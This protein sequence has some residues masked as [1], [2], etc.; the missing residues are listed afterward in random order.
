MG[1]QHGDDDRSYVTSGEVR[2]TIVTFI[3]DNTAFGL[4]DPDVFT[5]FLGFMSSAIAANVYPLKSLT[6]LQIILEKALEQMRRRRM[7]RRLLEE[8]R[9]HRVPESYRREQRE[10]QEAVNEL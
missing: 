8:G 7:R 4:T 9:I 1:R 10:S 6:N 2:T 3:G 5:R